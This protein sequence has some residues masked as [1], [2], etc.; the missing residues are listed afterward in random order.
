[1]SDEQKIEYG[2][3]NVTFKCPCCKNT[4]TEPYNEEVAIAEY[5]RHS[6]GATFDRSQLSMVCDPCY[7]KLCEMDGIVQTLQ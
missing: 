7:K 2:E 3:G 5:E 4:V 1:M 6:G